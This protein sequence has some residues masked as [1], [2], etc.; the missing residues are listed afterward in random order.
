MQTFINQDFLLTTE[1]SKKLFH[2]H[3]EF[4]PIIDYHCHL[5]PVFIA[6]NKRFENITQVWLEGDHYK[7]R[8]MRSFGIDEKFITGSASPEEKFIEWA[9]VV[10][11]TLR[12]PLYHWTHLELKRFFDIDDLLSLDTAEK[13]YKECNEKLNSE[14]FSTRNL[15]KKMNV[16]VVCTTDDPIDSLID[17]QKIRTDRFEIR[18][19]PTWRPDKA[20]AVGDP[21][22]FCTYLDALAKVCKTEISS[23]PDFLEALKKRHSYFHANGCRLSDHGIEEFYF[24]KCSTHEME[25]IFQKVKS[26]VKLDKKEITKYKS[27]MLYELA[28][29]NHEKSWVQQF[30]YGVLRNNNSLNYFSIGADTGFDSIGQFQVAKEMAQFFDRLNSE[31]SLTKTIVYNINASDNDMLA[32]MIGNFNQGGIRGKM[33]FGSAW[34]FND[35]KDGIEKHLN[36][37][38]NFN[39][40]STFVGMLTDSRSFLSFTRHEYFRRILCN[41][42]GDDIEKGLI[43][44]NVEHVGKIIEDICYNNAKGYFNF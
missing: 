1:T 12:N 39:L 11:Y 42:F 41:L 20:M 37:L 17:H 14:E 9:K 16:Q 3:A 23:Y 36:A 4:M 19:L 15:L 21:D 27:E 28:K 22:G 24:E 31:C 6:E 2:K 44:N 25:T 30:H 13:I 43:P 38:S 40:I 8:A 26:G 18:V 5:S 32:T 10:P 29:M 33:Q 34:W 7:W 35:Q